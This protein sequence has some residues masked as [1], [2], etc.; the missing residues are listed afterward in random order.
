MLV[1]LIQY[2]CIYLCLFK[3][4]LRI[5]IFFSFNAFKKLFF[6]SWIFIF[7]MYIS[8]RIWKPI[9]TYFLINLYFFV[10]KSLEI[11][12]FTLGNTF[13]STFFVTLF[14]SLSLSQNYFSFFSIFSVSLSIDLSPKVSLLLHLMQIYGR[15]RPCFPIRLWNVDIPDIHKYILLTS[16]FISVYCT[17]GENTIAITKIRNNNVAIHFSNIA[18]AILDFSLL[19]LVKLSLLILYGIGSLLLFLWL[20]L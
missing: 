12:Q 20:S 9:E 3:V 18:I 13:L 8:K 1:L 17:V 7:V 16:L 19:L 10:C 5:N 4:N 6:I 15:F 11:R 14:L 2:F